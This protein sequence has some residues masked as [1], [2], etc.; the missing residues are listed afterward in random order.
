MQYTIDTQKQ[1]DVICGLFGY[2]NVDGTFND[3][4]DTLFKCLAKNEAFIAG[5]AIS[6]LFTNRVVNDWDIFF[7]NEDALGRV[8][9][10]LHSRGW[11]N[12]QTTNLARSYKGEMVEEKY[13][14]KI[15]KGDIIIQLVSA[16]YGAPKDIFDT[17]DF[18]C[19]MGAFEFKNQEFY[20]DD[21]FFTDNMTKLLRYNYEGETNPVN[22]M[23]RVE[24]YKSYGYSI[25]TQ[26]IMKIALSIRKIKLDTYGDA[27]KFI[28]AIPFTNIKRLFM[29][30]LIDKP[31]GGMGINFN[32]EEGR[33]K[34]KNFMETKFDIDDMVALLNDLSCF[35]TCVVAGAKY[36]NNP[37]SPPQTMLPDIDPFEPF[38]IMKVTP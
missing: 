7:R 12:V 10:F 1:Y 34:F 31:L 36:N 2:R 26:E 32:T 5:G 14:E 17:F 8:A 15:C 4:K 3:D 9:S 25:S 28:Q 33:N 29:S 20:F 38:N 16:H 19:C 13:G 18:H 6:S 21:W 27:K 37:Y 30:Q 35:T 24:K 11:E 23:V 22:S